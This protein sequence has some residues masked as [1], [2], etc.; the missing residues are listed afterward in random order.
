M[1]VDKCFPCGKKI[2]FFTLILVL[3]PLVYGS[4]VD[5]STG[6]LSATFN[7]GVFQIEF[8]ATDNLEPFVYNVTAVTSDTTTTVTVTMNESANFTINYGTNSD[9]LGTIAS[10]STFQNPNTLVL[11][12]LV[13]STTY[14]FNITVCDRAPFYNCNTD[15]GTYSF[16]TNATATPTFQCN[17]GVDND[18]DSQIDFPAD[19]DCT[20]ATDDS[21]A[22]SGSGG[23]GGSSSSSSGGVGGG[24]GGGLN[25][26]AT[27]S[28]YSRFWDTIGPGL[29]DFLV[30]NDDIAVTKVEMDLNNQINSVSISLTRINSYPD[31]APIIKVLYQLFEVKLTNFDNDDITNVKFYFKIDKTWITANNIELDTVSAYRLT[32]GVWVPRETTYV[33]DM[34]DSYLFESTS[35]GFSLYAI[36]GKAK[37][38]PAPIVEPTDIEDTGEPII[39]EPQPAPPTEPITDEPEE[40]AQPVEEES[41]FFSLY[42]IWLLMLAIP[43]IVALSYLTMKSAKSPGIKTLTPHY[44]TINYGTN[45]DTLGTIAST[46]TFQNPNTIVHLHNCVI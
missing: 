45:S 41:N 31:D 35:S 3:M 21:E 44:F 32:N 23:G 34:G 29:V 26:N 8:L 5:E 1:E 27:G 28:T 25:L 10:T 37:F 14:Y 16:T 43:I 42:G 33:G 4:V 36:A 11:A 2:L 19:T 17:D 18:G 9:T 20:S 40:I 7:S 39:I 12:P 30:N 38:V 24:G 15:N 6:N 13:A 22:A 46:S